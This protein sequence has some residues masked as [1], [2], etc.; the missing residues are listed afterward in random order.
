MAYEILSASVTWPESPNY[1]AAADLDIALVNPNTQSRAD[2]CFVI[3]TDDTQPTLPANAGYPLQAREARNVSLKSG[4]RVW[5]AAPD[6]GGETAPITLL[7][8][9]P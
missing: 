1:T 5:L 3:T 7:S 2:A 9:T 6:I 8:L 4:D